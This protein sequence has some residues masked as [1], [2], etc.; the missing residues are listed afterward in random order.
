MKK[1]QEVGKRIAISFKARQLLVRDMTYLLNSMT[2]VFRHAVILTNES[3][4]ATLNKDEYLLRISQLQ[5]GRRTSLSLRVAAT[6]KAVELA[7]P[8]AIGKL[9]DELADHMFRVLTAEG[10]T[11]GRVLSFKKSIENKA[12]RISNF[13]ARLINTL[14]DRSEKVEGSVRWCED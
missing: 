6:K 4:G 3:I 9:R 2:T 14:P 5:H 1:Q 8:E 13:T 10:E 7:T 12:P 11:P